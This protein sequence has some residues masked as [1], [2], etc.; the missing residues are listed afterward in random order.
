MKA[1]NRAIV[2][3]KN[4]IVWLDLKDGEGIY[5][6][7]VRAC[8]SMLVG[9]RHLPTYIYICMYVCIYMYVWVATLGRARRG[10]TTPPHGRRG[11]VYV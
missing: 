5:E 7:L 9:S 6:P 8:V 1:T 2:N 3:A 4:N 11:S 10:R